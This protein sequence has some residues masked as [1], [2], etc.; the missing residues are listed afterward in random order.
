MKQIVW[1]QSAQR[2]FVRIDDWYRDTAPEYSIRVGDAAIAAGRFLCDFPLAGSQTSRE[3]L[4]KWPVPDTDFLIF[5]SVTR[6]TIEI[7]R[8][9]HAREDWQDSE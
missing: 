4:R 8:I 7:V 2:D 5:Y 3:T 6:T 9:R 1:T